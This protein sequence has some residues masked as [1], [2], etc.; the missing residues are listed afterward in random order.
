MHEVCVRTRERCL[1]ISLIRTGWKRNVLCCDNDDV[2][3]HDGDSDDFKGNATNVE[4]W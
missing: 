4:I 2:G 1:I 3:D